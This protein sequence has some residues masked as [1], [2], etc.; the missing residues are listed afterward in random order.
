MSETDDLIRKMFE[1][2]SQEQK[3][4]SIQIIHQLCF[5][6]CVLAYGQKLTQ[7]QEICLEDCTLNFKDARKLVQ[8]VVLETMKN[9]VN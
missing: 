2:Y 7:N 3:I 4:S 8:Q 5:K 1:G 9:K 6:K